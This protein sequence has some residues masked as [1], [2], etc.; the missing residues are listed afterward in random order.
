[1]SSK[2]IC[3]ATSAPSTII[4]TS[5]IRASRSL[6]PRIFILPEPHTFLLDGCLIAPA[7][8]VVE[9]D[10]VVFAEVGPRLHFNNFKRHA[11]GILKA[12]THAER[13]IGRFVFAQQKFFFSARDERCAADDD[14]VL[15][16]VVMHLQ[17]QASTRIHHDA[18]HLEPL[19]VID[20]I[21]ETPWAANLSMRIGFR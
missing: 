3:D 5:N 13:D 18:L 10:N 21:V 2:R 15:R 20:G 16:T 11:T 8:L 12:V 17:R 19:A 4:V 6:I 14:P 9:S 1:M 7:I